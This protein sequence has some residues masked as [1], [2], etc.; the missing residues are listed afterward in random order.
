MAPTRIQWFSLSFNMKSIES[1]SL[2]KNSMKSSILNINSIVCN[3]F[4]QKLNSFPWVLHGF[5][6][7]HWF[8]VRGGIIINGIRGFK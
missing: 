5:E 4:Y 1:L 2:K 7:D 6:Q 8:D 3:N